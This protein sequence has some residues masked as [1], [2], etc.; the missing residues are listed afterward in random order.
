MEYR[1]TKVMPCLREL[2]WLT[3]AEDD[4]DMLWYAP[5]HNQVCR[6]LAESELREG[7]SANIQLAKY[8]AKERLERLKH[9]VN[10]TLDDPACQ[11][12]KKYL[13]S[14]IS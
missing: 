10:G 3:D 5:L 12:I 2:K 1:E 9:S 8:V 7:I 13:L 6:W 11:E 14:W 4:E